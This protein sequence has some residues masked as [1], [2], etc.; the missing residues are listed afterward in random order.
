[1]FVTVLVNDLLGIWDI[2]V[3]HFLPLLLRLLVLLHGKEPLGEGFGFGV[4]SVC[5]SIALKLGGCLNAIG[6]VFGRR[7]D[8]S[9]VARMGCAHCNICLI[10]FSSFG[11]YIVI[12]GRTGASSLLRIL[13]VGL[14]IA[15][16]I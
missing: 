8:V 16:L 10:S 13:V 14:L 9:G 6:G 11:W 15:L 1:M 5:D 3:S 2:Q 12:K 4:G 7:W